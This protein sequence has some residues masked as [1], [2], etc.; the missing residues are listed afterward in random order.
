MTRF[1][2][3]LVRRRH[4]RRSRPQPKLGLSFRER[5]RLRRVRGGWCAETRKAGGAY[6]A[7]RV[8]ALRAFAIAALWERR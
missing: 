5:P 3:D 6:G 2:G 4:K 1:A 7:T 8:D